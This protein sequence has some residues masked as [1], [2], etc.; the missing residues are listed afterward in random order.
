[1][2]DI[3]SS[4]DEQLCMDPVTDFVISSSKWLEMASQP[5]ILFAT[6]VVDLSE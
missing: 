3:C 4:V 1:M 2:P 5:S 6:T